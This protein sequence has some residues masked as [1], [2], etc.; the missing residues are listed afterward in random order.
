MQ[1]LHAGYLLS[2]ASLLS[3]VRCIASHA[4]SSVFADTTN[5]SAVTTVIARF[6]TT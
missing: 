5:S 4:S 6:W 1:A 3:T 2:L